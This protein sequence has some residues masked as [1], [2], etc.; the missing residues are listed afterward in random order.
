MEFEFY[1]SKSEAIAKFYDYKK[2]DTMFAQNNETLIERNIPKK[3]NKNTFK[4]KW[5]ILCITNWKFYL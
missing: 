4:T 1:T 3:Q 5:K 2:F